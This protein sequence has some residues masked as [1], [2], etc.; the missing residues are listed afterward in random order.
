MLLN[1]AKYS[2][3]R[4]RK[5]T[6]KVYDPAV[7]RFHALLT[8]ITWS[9]E[10]YSYKIAD[11]DASGTPSKNGLLINGVRT[12]AASLQSNDII[13]LGSSVRLVYQVNSFLD[14]MLLK[15]QDFENILPCLDEDTAVLSPK[16]TIA[17]IR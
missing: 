16:M 14:P 5:D 8:R 6:I 7:S 2:I 11:G 17:P 13:Q 1:A 15:S 3:G 9:P 10:H 4:D 12:N